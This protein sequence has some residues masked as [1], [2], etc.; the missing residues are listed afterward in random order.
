MPALSVVSDT[1]FIPLLGRIYASSYHPYILYDEAALAVYDKL[2]Q[3]IRDMPGQT[4]YASLASAVRSANMDRCIHA[5]LS[6]HP[7]AVIVNLGC[8]LETLY[9]RGDNGRAVWYELDLPEVL[10]LRSQY[11]PETDRD[12]YLPYSM[13]DYKWMD[14]V[15]KAGKTHM[16]AIAS[17]LFLYFSEEQ[18][19]DCIRHLSSLPNAEI[20][21]DTL[22]PAGMKVAR[23]MID[24]MGKQEAPVY[25]CVDSA[26]AFAAKIS[27]GIHIMEEKPFYNLVNY[28]SEMAFDTRL[29]MAFSDLFNMVKII[30]LQL[31]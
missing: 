11:F 5:F 12:R 1:L 8:G 6:A 16:M 9:Q 29:R 18:V 30:H 27:A 31:Y 26:G 23:R 2:E 10:E 7:D 13:F 24:R 4:E 14:A 28:R 25:F 21:F 19:I 15:E 3:R 22:S 17:G 20:V